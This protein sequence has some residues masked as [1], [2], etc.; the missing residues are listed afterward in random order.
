MVPVEACPSIAFVNLRGKRGLSG[1]TVPNHSCS[2]PIAES[3]RAVWRFLAMTHLDS[4]LVLP[5]QVA[6]GSSI[7]VCPHPKPPCLDVHSSHRATA[8][9]LQSGKWA[10][11]AVTPH[12]WLSSKLFRILL[13]FELA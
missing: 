12:R 11:A 3:L 9:C 2:L 6:L 13:S 4:C 10:I 1:A 7:Q 8:P 5:L